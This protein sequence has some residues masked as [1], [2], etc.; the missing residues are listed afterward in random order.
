MKPGDTITIGNK[1]YRVSLPGEWDEFPCMGC[2]F[3][4]GN[5]ACNL[6]FEDCV[7]MDEGKS[8]YEHLI[9]VVV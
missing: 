8:V 4:G 5:G 3:D 9:F 7:L 6:P 2:C 1:M